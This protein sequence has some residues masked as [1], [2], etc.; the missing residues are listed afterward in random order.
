MKNGQF[1]EFFLNL[2]IVNLEYMKNIPSTIILH[3]GKKSL[4][5]TIMDDRYI[6]LVFNMY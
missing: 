2:F 1:Y 6:S 3:I 5:I 4:M